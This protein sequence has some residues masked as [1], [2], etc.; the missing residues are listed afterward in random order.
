MLQNANQ[1]KDFDVVLGKEVPPPLGGVVLGGLA[2]VKHRLTSK[3]VE[4]RIAALKEALKYE[5]AGLELVIQAL[6]DEA[7]EVRNAACLLFGKSEQLYL[8]KKGVKIW[9]KWREY[10]MRLEGCDVDLSGFNLSGF[11]LRGFN[12]SGANLS[13]CKLMRTDL[14]GAFLRTANL[15]N[16]DLC[17]AN[18]NEAY[19]SWANLSSANLNGTNLYKANLYGADLRFATLIEVIMPDGKILE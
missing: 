7:Q 10:S 12:L 16:A 11:N 5:D 6:D 15:R 14:S 3:V 1:P 17:F 2:G 8:L 18:L 13:K 9:N 19:L 4:H